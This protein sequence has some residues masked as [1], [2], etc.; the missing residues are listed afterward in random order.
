MQLRTNW[1][2][3]G[4]IA[5]GSSLA[6]LALAHAPPAAALEFGELA[7]V[8]RS[9]DRADLF[10]IDAVGRSVWHMWPADSA[11]T[12]AGP[13]SLGGGV[14]DITPVE[15][16]DDRFEVFAVGNENGIWHTAQNYDTW[17]WPAWQR[18]PGE[19]KRVAAA[20]AADGTVALFYVGTDDAVWYGTR[21][22]DAAAFGDWTSLGFTA[23]DVAVTAALSGGFDVYA[24]GADD[25]TSVA[26]IVPASTEEPV[27]V[28]LGGRARSLSA[29]HASSGLDLVAE[30]GFD[31]AVWIQQ[32]T[33]EGWSGW[34]SLG[35]GGKRAELAELQGAV[36]LLTL[37]DSAVVS[38]SIAGPEGWGEWTRVVEASPLE[39]RFRGT[40]ALSIPDQD[41]EDDRDIE[42]AIRFDVS[43]RQ[44][45]LTSFPAITTDPFDTPFGSSR[46]TVTL[47]SSAQGRFD[48]ESGSL[49]IP[50]TLQFDQSLD[51]PL[52]NED[53]RAS[54]DLST[55]GL[56]GAAFER[57]SGS[58]ALG[59]S[60]S[61]QGIGGGINPLDG[62]EVRVVID[63]VLDPS[64]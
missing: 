22:A 50:V 59:D 18:V 34:S 60:A 63:G 35:G 21:A 28:N 12:W 6:G 58:L 29:I 45:S 16:R 43:R 24:I 56:G 54:F 62:L 39:S 5:V 20:K 36:A 40:A 25:S 52:I 38:Q 49:Q 13:E 27:W 30:I 11:G 10:G 4:V 17:A 23:K 48:P 7:I 61:F 55:S 57:E 37:S 31:D 9:E 42:L 41:V 33:A 44:V 64:P 15:V 32:R 51:V 53:A 3:A 1:A 14:L 26:R 2:R 46:S 19:A 47:V 8:N